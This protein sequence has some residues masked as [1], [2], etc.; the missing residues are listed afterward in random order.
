MTSNFSSTAWRPLLTGALRRSALEAVREIA[1]S[2]PSHIK[3]AETDDSLASGKSGLAVTYAYLAQSGIGNNRETAEYLNR[4]RQLISSATRQMSS[5]VMA[6]SLHCGFTGAAWSLTHLQREFFGFRGLDRKR[7]PSRA[8]DEAL[9]QDSASAD[10]DLIDGLVGLGVYAL[11]RLPDPAAADCLNRIVDQ[12]AVRAVYQK[13]GITFATQSSR[14]S[15]LKSNNNQTNYYDLGV[16]HGIAGVIGLLAAVCSA[17][18][19][20]EKA[21]AL[22]N[23]TVKWLISQKMESNVRGCFP[24]FVGPGI[25]RKRARLAWCYGDAGIAAVLLVA[26]RSVKNSSWE[27]EALRIAQGAARRRADKAGIVDAGLC[28]GSA[29]LGHIFNRI[30]QATGTTWSQKAGWFWFTHALDQR[31]SGEGVGGFLSY[32][33]DDKNQSL[34]T[35]EIGLLEGAAGIA[36]ALLAAA[37][38]LAPSWDRVLL[39]S[40]AT[41][42][43]G[44]PRKTLTP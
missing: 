43:S 13:G 36:L 14:S 9:C 17:G 1:A 31:R 39:L 26:A 22:L 12:L 10:Y 33:R 37:S 6:P 28:H 15:A 20:Y 29:G 5:E 21:R 44:T 16:A 2:L 23:E 18:V 11:E 25:R 7:K 40:P 42:N 34:W 38:S 27:R 19:A 32:T 24:Y 41:N 4:A 3:R 30:F 35:E 8:L